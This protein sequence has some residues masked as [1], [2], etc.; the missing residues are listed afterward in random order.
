MR[1]HSSNFKQIGFTE[2]TPLDAMAALAHQQGL[3]CV[4]DL[5]SGALLD[6]AA[7]GLDPEPTVQA[8]V[9]AGADVIAF[10]GD[11]LLGGPQA[12]ILIGKRELIDTLKRHPLARAIRADKLCLAALVATLDH[13]RKG[14][15]LTH[16]PV[17]QMIARPLDSIRA[18][19][20]HWR[21]Q[22]I[23]QYPT[24][25]ADVITG[26]STVGGGSLPGATIPTWLLHLTVPHADAVTARIRQARIPVIARI[27]D[28]AVVFD[29]RTVLRGQETALLTVLHELI[30]QGLPTVGQ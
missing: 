29:P 14:E 27:Q 19:A 2:A 25:Q 3:C 6:T 26:E 7:F 21:T 4:D 22:L 28:D 8:S 17:W 11:K 9:A 1:V 30:A 20:E 15:A 10:S 18:T 23:E 24:L 5:G 12:G 16:I 13:Y